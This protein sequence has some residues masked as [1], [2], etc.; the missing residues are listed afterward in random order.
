MHHKMRA[1][2]G[3]AGWSKSQAMSAFR[4]LGRQRRH[5]KQAELITFMRDR[6]RAAELMF[7]FSVSRRR[8]ERVCRAF[9]AGG[10]ADLQWSL[11]GPEFVRVPRG[12]VK[13]L[14]RSGGSQYF[15]LCESPSDE[16]AGAD[17][18]I[19]RQRPHAH[20]KHKCACRTHI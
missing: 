5:G 19:V 12:A 13:I 10:R 2:M 20:L 15:P 18:T 8:R 11:G 4:R 17:E 16:S 7:E 1:M 14:V 6:A 3:G 9:W